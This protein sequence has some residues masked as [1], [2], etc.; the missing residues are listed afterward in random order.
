MLYSM[1][2]GLAGFWRA[3]FTVFAST[4][5]IVVALTLIGVIALVGYHVNLIT[6]SLQ[7]QSGEVE[8]FL[9]E[10]DENLAEELQERLAQRPGIESTQYISQ[11]EAEAIFMEDFGEEGDVFLDENFLPASVKIR[12]EPAYAN[13]DSLAPL[14]EQVETWDGVEEIVFNRNLLERVQQNLGIV[15]LV[16]LT[17]GVLIT[18]ACIFLVA[19]TIR[20]TIYARRLLIRTMKLVGAT[21]PFIRRPFLFEG[22]FQGMLGGAIAG[23]IVWS[24][25]L[26]LLRYIPLLE[27]QGWPGGHPAVMITALVLLGMLLG[28]LGSWFATRRFIRKVAVS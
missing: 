26:A 21:D 16:T 20:L 2:E 1:K 22:L 24:L 12:V 7:Q 5:A 25:H 6:T 19:N 10:P 14:I 17:V 9:E 4:S 13:V 15:Y 27:A 28:L 18:L 3:R 23:F 11:E 8:V